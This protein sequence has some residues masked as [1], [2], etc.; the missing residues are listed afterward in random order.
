MLEA[1]EARTRASE[2]VKRLNG[3]YI[4]DDDWDEEGFIL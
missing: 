2:M 3:A 4:H 1:V